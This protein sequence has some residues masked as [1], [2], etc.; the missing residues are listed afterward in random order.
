MRA[1][2]SEPANTSTAPTTPPRTTTPRTTTPRTRVG[3]AGV[4]G[5]SGRQLARLLAGHP[6]FQLAFASSDALAGNRLSRL[7]PDLGADGEAMV[8]GHVDTLPAA[9]DRGCELVFM[10]FKSPDVGDR[11]GAELVRAGVRVVDLTGAHRI[12]ETVQHLIAYGFEPVSPELNGKA[13]YGLT[14]WCDPGV[15]AGAELVANPGSLP[16]AVLLAM[17]PLVEQELLVHDTLVVDAKS[18][19][20]AA[21]RSPR[22]ALLHSEVYSNFHA[23]RVGRHPHTPEIA[24]ELARVSGRP[25]PL[26]FVTHMLPIARG[27][28]ATCYFRV[29]GHKDSHAAAEVVRATLARRYADSPFIHILDSAEDVHLTAVVGTNRCLLSATADPF[30]NRVVVVVAIDNLLKGGAGQALQNAN[31]MIGYDETDGLGLGTGGRP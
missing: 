30:G 26:S 31:R 10:S 29:A 21:G 22:V 12:R 19:T 25:V 18:G 13:I 17:L 11:I 3:I 23:Y 4:R 8:V 1:M 24:Q 2:P 6:H 9:R 27:V 7:D 14:E 5:Y 16:T 28:L 20:T 15:I